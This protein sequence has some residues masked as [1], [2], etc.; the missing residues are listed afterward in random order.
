M[1]AAIEHRE[2]VWAVTVF[3]GVMAANFFDLSVGLVETLAADAH[4]ADV[5]AVHRQA[6]EFP[7]QTML[8]C[9]NSSLTSLRRRSR[10]ARSLRPRTGFCSPLQDL[11][12]LS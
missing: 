11:R 5:R 2:A 10:C 8:P 3:A 9:C 4:A 7:A 12:L 6:A 1:I